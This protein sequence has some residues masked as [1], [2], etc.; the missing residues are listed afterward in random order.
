MNTHGDC[1]IWMGSDEDGKAKRKQK[2]VL[3]A[4]GK[5][6]HDGCT[7]RPTAL[8]YSG[9]YGQRPDRRDTIQRHLPYHHRDRLGV[10]PEELL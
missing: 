4:D 3:Q 10:F 5:G 8:L 7:D 6:D 9:V 2:N 1:T